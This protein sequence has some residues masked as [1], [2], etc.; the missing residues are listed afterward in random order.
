MVA[1]PTLAALVVAVAFAV[2][3]D[4]AFASGP[5]VSTANGAVEG[6]ADASGLQ[7]RGIPYASPPVGT[8]RWRP[9]APA[10]PWEGLRDG[11][12]FASPCLQPSDF[13]DEGNATATL[14]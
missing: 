7:W 2:A 13:D 14:G 3:A 9:P 1:K 6:V 5:V 11:T 12:E 8:L 10:A 4:T